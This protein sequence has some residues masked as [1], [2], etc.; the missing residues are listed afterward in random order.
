MGKQ[1]YYFYTT[2]ITHYTHT[3]THTHTRTW[4]QI[5]LLFLCFLSAA[6]SSPLR[7][8]KYNTITLYYNLSCSLSLSLSLSLC[9][10]L[11]L[12]KL[13]RARLPLSTVS[14]KLPTSVL[15]HQVQRTKKIFA[16]QFCP[17]ALQ[18]RMSSCSHA[19]KKKQKTNT[20]SPVRSGH[21]CF[22]NRRK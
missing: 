6:G 20:S 1:G 3:H 5:S 13:L 8:L 14:L 11:A 12:L 18:G 2:T 9:C 15:N 4:I 16:G 19:R 7:V 17:V 10:F 22:D 21:I